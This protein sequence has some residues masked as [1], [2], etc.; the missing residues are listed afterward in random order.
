MLFTRRQL[1]KREAPLIYQEA[2]LRV[3]HFVT[4][5]NVFA[6]LFVLYA[7][8]MNLKLLLMS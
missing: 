4:I 8:K 1:V 3:N 2:L 5:L 7:A 6:T